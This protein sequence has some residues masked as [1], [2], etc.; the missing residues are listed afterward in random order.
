MCITVKKAIQKVL[1]VLFSAC[2]AFSVG[3]VP[4]MAAEAPTVDSVEYKG[5]GKVEVEFYEDVSYKNT[6]VT[7]KDSSGR[8]YR[9]REY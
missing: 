2:V 5:S 6:R 3:A 8:N 9:G 7:V 1:C 4:G